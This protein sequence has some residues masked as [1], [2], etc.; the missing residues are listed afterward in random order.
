MKAMQLGTKKTNKLVKPR[1]CLSNHGKNV[2]KNCQADIRERGR[3]MQ[4]ATD[5][6]R[7]TPSIQRSAPESPGGTR[8]PGKSV[9][10]SKASKNTQTYG[11]KVSVSTSEVAEE[12]VDELGAGQPAKNY[13]CDR[14]GHWQDANNANNGTHTTRHPHQH[15]GTGPASRKSKQKMYSTTAVTDTAINEQKDTENLNKQGAKP[16]CLPNK[17]EPQ[18]RARDR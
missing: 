13:R 9:I 1:K 15:R 12:E 14:P 3:N 18:R 8:S 10:I 6:S 17:R 2:K 16:S 5:E 4:H 11:V 7:H